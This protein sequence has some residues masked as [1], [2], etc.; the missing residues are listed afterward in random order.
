MRRSILLLSAGLMSLVAPRSAGAKC[1]APQRHPVRARRPARADRDARD[2]ARDGRG[3]RQ[4]RQFRESARAV[5]DLHH[6]Q[7]L[8]DGDRPL[9][10]AIP[11]TSATRSITGYPVGPA[12]G[13]VTPFLEIDPVLRD[14]DEHF[15]GD[16]LNEDDRCSKMA[17]ANGL[18][19]G[20]DRQARPDADFRSHRQDRRRRPAFDRDRRLHRQQQRRSACRTK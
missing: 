3:P 15:G 4:G 16:Y 11:A 20:R 12:D 2:R 8:G 14:V 5:S 13:T 19:H 10:S 9:T 6:R 1:H 17:R 18:Q 7:C